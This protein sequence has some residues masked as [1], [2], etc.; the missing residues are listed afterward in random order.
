MWWINY[1]VN[2]KQH[3]EKVG[4]KS[5]AIDLYRK[6]KEDDRSGR[7]LPTLRNT[8]IVTIS[9]L[10]DLMLTHI[11][12]QHH[13]DQRTYESRGEIVRKALGDKSAE[14]VTPQELEKWLGKHCKTPATFNRYKA[15]VSLA[16]KLGLQ[17]KKVT[18]NP[19]RLIPQRKEPKGRLRFLSR[20]EYDKLQGVIARRFP[21]HLAEFVTAVHTGMRLSEQYTIE[22]GQFDRHRRA[23]DLDKTKNGDARTVH[24]N[25]D[26]LAAIQSVLHPKIKRSDR[27]F[28]R[29]DRYG[30]TPAVS[31]RDSTIVPGSR[32][33]SKRQRFPESPGTAYAIRFVLG[34]PWLVRPHAKSWRPLDTRR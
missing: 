2:G 27:I 1:Y 4:R 28:P 9:E 29:E 20:E 8:A 34:S 31:R 12:T 25:P 17:N 23:V 5:A 19:A 10:I 13:K 14:D 7:K 22:A 16:Y 6:R 33:L 24:L 18:H 30:S 3:R 26:A 11:K 21:E 15:L 32:P